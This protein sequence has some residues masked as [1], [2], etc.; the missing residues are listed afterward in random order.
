MYHSP[1]RAK[2]GNLRKTPKYSKIYK[3]ASYLNKPPTSEYVRRKL[4]TKYKDVRFTSQIT[5]VF[6][7]ESNL[8]S[9][10]SYENR[11]ARFEDF[12]V[13]QLVIEHANGPIIE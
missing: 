13:K 3:V 4:I 12:E 1:G 8:L 6:W 10:Q 11:L 9:T 7:P 5:P 2:A